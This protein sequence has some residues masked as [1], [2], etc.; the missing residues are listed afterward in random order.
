[1]AR[2]RFTPEER[3]ILVPGALVKYNNHGHHHDATVIGEI[4]RT[5]GRDSVPIRILKSRGTMTA[6]DV[7]P[8]DPANIVI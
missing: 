6:G 2:R 4:D 5:G 7:F 3:E 8:A 1:M